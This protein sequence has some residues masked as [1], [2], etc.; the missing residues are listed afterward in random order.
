MTAG[1]L[2]LAA[3]GA[4]SLAASLVHVAA[5]VGGPS[6]FRWLGAGERIARGVGMGHKA[7]IILT[8]GI[9]AA[10][11]VIALAAFAGAG[12]IRPIPFTRVVLIGASA[13]YLAR[14]MV[15]FAPS[16]LRRPDL[17]QAFLVISSGIVLVMGIAF[18]LGTFLQ[19]PH[20]S[21]QGNS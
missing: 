16:L 19:W 21:N 14:G 11:L 6:W 10:L 18:A 13:V 17:S 3:G 2:L 1:R 15:L 12:L 4:M 8:I 7:P 20:L 9:A 5:I